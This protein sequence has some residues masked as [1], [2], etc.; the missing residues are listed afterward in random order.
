LTTKELNEKIEKIFPPQNNVKFKDI[1]DANIL[2]KNYED[3]PSDKSVKK[4]RFIEN[5]YSKIENFVFRHLLEKYSVGYQFSKRQYHI[6]ISWGCK[7]NCSYCAIKKAVGPLRSKPLD[8]CIKEFKKGLENNY[9]NFVLDATDVGLYGIDI[10]NSF[11]EILDEMT[12]I[13]GEYKISIRE[14]HPVWIVKYADELEKIVKRNKILIFDVAL[15]SANTRI[16]KL[17]NRY[18]NVDKMKEAI[19]KIKKSAT[20]MF[21]TIECIVGFPTETWDE[22]LD[23][24][25]FIKEVDSSGGQ[26]YLFSCKTGTEAEKIEPK[27]PNEEIYKRLNYAKRYLKNVRYYTKRIPGTRNLMFVKC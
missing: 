8:E 24:T 17:M 5:I 18:S 7:G 21:L 23:T 25:N 4:L 22:F 10:G 9:K 15:Q 1:P 12:K 14:L 20:D 19:L 11:P 6:R 2:F 3:I 13:P 26:I 16:L 27:V